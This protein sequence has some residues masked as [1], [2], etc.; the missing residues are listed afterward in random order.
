MK[1]RKLSECNPG[2]LVRQQNAGIA[3]VAGEAG[4]NLTL[5]QLA[6]KRGFLRYLIQPPKNQPLVSYG[7]DFSI[8]V[9]QGDT[10]F[11]PTELVGLPGVL[12]VSGTQL[13]L[14]A[15]PPGHQWGAAF[16][17]LV[18]GEFVDEP[19]ASNTARFPGWRLSVSSSYPQ[20]RTE[21][22]SFDAKG[23]QG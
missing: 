5:V 1:I 6:S 4:A 9:L 8:D 18:S 16:V 7:R 20:K 10:E 11:G 22:F 3:I 17:D 23:E 12:W 15:A 19:S 2:D 21:F 14:A 13:I